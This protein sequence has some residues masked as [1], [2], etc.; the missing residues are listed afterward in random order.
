MIRIEFDNGDIAKLSE[1]VV[2]TYRANIS[3]KEEHY[4]IG[5]DGWNNNIEFALE[6]DLVIIEWFERMNWSDFSDNLIFINKDSEADHEEM[7]SYSE[8]DCEIQP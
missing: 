5:S 2:A 8:Y 1:K 6:D 4:D 3:A 7:F